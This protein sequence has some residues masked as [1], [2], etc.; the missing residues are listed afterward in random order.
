MLSTILFNLYINNLLDFLNK[1]SN[2]EKDQ[3]RIPQ[4]DNVTINNLLFADD[5]TILPWSK[6]DLQRRYLT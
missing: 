5:W 2:T 1:E 3:L 6:Y 4:L